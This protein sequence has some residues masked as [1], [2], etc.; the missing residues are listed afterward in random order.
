MEPETEQLFKQ[1]LKIQIWQYRLA[2]ISRIVIIASIIFSLYF[3]YVYLMPLILN[4]IQKT[5][6]LLQD[7]NPATQTQKVQDNLFKNLQEQVQK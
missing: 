3:S 1:W 4:Q 5:N 6:T 7:L 2:M